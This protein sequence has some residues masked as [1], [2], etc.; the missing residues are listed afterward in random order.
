MNNLEKMKKYLCDQIMNATAEEF[1]EIVDYLEEYKS[2]KSPDYR[3]SWIDIHDFF[4]C[5]KCR[6][7]Y[8]CDTEND[9]CSTCIEN[10]RKY[11]EL[12][13]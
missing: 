7:M 6:R 9:T 5:D 13:A 4:T 2:L 3:F 10:F 12:E 8:G 1:K 11:C